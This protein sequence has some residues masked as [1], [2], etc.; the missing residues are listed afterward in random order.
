[1]AAP[2]QLLAWREAL[3]RARYAG[4]RTVE[5][6]G[7]KVEYRSDSEMASALADLERRLGTSTR[8][9]QVRI[10]SSKGV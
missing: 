3:L 1:M 6:D 10:N 5:C 8:V 4:T 9:T 7:R 2:D